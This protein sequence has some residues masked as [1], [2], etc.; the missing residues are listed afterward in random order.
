M[1]DRYLLA[2]LQRQY[3]RAWQNL[4]IEV[5]KL[6]AAVALDATDNETINRQRIRAEMVS[7]E[8]R[9]ARDALAKHLMQTGV[10]VE[11]SLAA[12]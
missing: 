2:Q 12:V 3:R 7:V 5:E 8:Y 1:N 11:D 10:R 4:I 6:Q 9:D